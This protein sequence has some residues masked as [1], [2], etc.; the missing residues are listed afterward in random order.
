MTQ[1]PPPPHEAVERLEL[2]KAQNLASTRLPMA[3]RVARAE[4]RE[5]VAL[6]CEEASKTILQLIAHLRQVEEREAVMREALA[7][8]AGRTDS[9]PFWATSIE[10]IK[11]IAR[12]ALTHSPETDG[13]G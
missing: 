5:G 13:E 8:I 1:A 2:D 11:S 9:G 12:T 4:D 10:A 7:V 3:A 6:T